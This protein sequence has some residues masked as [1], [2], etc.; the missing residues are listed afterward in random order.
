MAEKPKILLWDLETFPNLVTSWGLRVYGYLSPDN[1]V[2]ERTIICGS[3]KLLG[4]AG[5]QSACVTAAS[6]TDD[7]H[8]VEALHKA[9]TG[10]DAVIAH[11]GDSFDMRWLHARVAFHGLLP[12]PPVIQIDTKKIAKKKFNFNSNK[13]DYLAQ[14]FKIGK[15]IKTEFDLW[16]QCLAGD[17]KALA[18]MVRYNRHDIVILESVYNKL[19]PYVSTRVNAQLFTQRSA[20]PNC[21]SKNVQ[22][23]GFSYTVAHKYQ[24]LQCMSC[25]GWHRS[26]KAEK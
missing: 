4:K 9:V 1:I 23:R 13:L 22:A 6:P 15:K 14:Y 7:R 16:K 26:Q 20:C 25:G 12:L 24:R 2:Q 5:I 18:K 8:V 11:N 21:G 3:W 10:V 17:E 19:A